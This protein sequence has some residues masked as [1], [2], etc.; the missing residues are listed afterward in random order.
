MCRV[1]F[2]V[3]LLFSEAWQFSGER[4]SFKKKVVFKSAAICRRKCV[5]EKRWPLYGH[6]RCATV[7]VT[8]CRARRTSAHQHITR[9]FALASVR[10]ANTVETGA[11]LP[12]WPAASMSQHLAVYPL[13]A[14][15]YRVSDVSS[16]RRLRVLN[17]STPWVFVR[18]NYSYL[19]WQ[20]V[21]GCSCHTLE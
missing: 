8:V 7:D 1:G 20:G 17:P 9:W 4:L 18:H 21:S 19:R 16:H 5:C 10:W 2:S 15:V 6:R 3:M 12:W 14:S 13:S 11:W